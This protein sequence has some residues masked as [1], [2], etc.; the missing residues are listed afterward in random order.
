VPMAKLRPILLGAS[1]SQARPAATTV[2]DHDGLNYVFAGS[3]SY[4][5]S[6]DIMLSVFRRLHAEG[7]RAQLT[8][9]GGVS[10][11]RLL[12]EIAVTPNAHHQSGVAQSV[13]F[14]KL[15]A[16]DCLLLPSRFDSFGMVVAEAMACGIPA[17][18][19]S[20]VGAKALIERFPA[21]G[22]IVEP[23]ADSLYECLRSQLSNPSAVRAARLNALQASTNFTWSAYRARVGALF[24]E[25][26]S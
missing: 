12:D 8:L 20:Q 19:S 13:L 9:I 11:P 15:A 16:A 22:W 25:F 24:E 26:L 17:V 2:Q 6:V 7:E 5:K 18:V 10:D 23:N 21:A 3:L 4:R 14:E 1:V